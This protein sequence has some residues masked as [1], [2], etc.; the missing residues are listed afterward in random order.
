VISR[1]PEETDPRK[2]LPV[3]ILQ[4]EEIMH[5]IE[6]VEKEINLN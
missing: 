4:D 2:K 6:I 1:N 5:D 3:V